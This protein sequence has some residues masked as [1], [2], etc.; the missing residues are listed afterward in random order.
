MN[1][2]S[3]TKLVK[4]RKTAKVLHV[5]LRICSILML[6]WALFFL[7][8]IIGFAVTDD[9]PR[10]TENLSI[11]MPGF[12]AVRTA[13]LTTADLPRFTIIAVLPIAIIRY[14]IFA[15]IFHISAL[16]CKNISTRITPFSPD[17]ARKTALL[18]IPL[19]ILVI[20]QI[21][22]GWVAAMI[23]YGRF[24]PFRFSLLQIAFGISFFLFSQILVFIFEH[25]SILQTESDEIV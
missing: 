14:M 24:V 18:R 10:F 19:I 13:T 3:Y 5:I 2:M 7:V 8:L 21:F 16:I 15:S 17:I 11:L 6:A 22:A 23:I 12:H 20:Y 4:M 9:I 1:T 25:G